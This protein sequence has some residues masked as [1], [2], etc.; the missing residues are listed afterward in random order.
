M[1]EKGENY[2]RKVVMSKDNVINR[3]ESMKLNL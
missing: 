3:E 2:G 1:R